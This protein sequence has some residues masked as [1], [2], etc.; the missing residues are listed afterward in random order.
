MALVLQ[1]EAKE[2][3][4]FNGLQTPLE[5]RDRRAALGFVVASNPQRAAG[6]Q[7]LQDVPRSDDASRAVCCHDA[8]IGTQKQIRPVAMKQRVLVLQ[9]ASGSPPSFVSRPPQAKIKR[10][11]RTS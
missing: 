2:T 5:T 1:N 10:F 7:N 9:E 3:R 4:E 6:A 11:S 8:R